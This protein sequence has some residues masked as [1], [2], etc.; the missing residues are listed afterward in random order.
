VYD[1]GGGAGCGYEG[2]PLAGCNGYGGGTGGLGYG[3]IRVVG[4]SVGCHPTG[5]AGGTG[6]NATGGN[7]TGGTATGGTATGGIPTGE[8]ETGSPDG[9]VHMPG[10]AAASAVLAFDRWRMS[11][12]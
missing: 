4:G 8:P 3:A 7:A 9:G 6:G 1:P 5:L 10:A 12:I 2:A 11:T